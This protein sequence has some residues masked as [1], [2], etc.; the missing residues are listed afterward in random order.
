MDSIWE[1]FTK[2]YREKSQIALLTWAY[3][4]IAAAVVIISG[5]IALINQSVGVSV[6]IVPLVSIVAMCANIVV[7]SLIRFILDMREQKEKAKT[8]AAKR[9][10]EKTKK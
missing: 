2:M 10:S 9:S 8:R 4:I 3:A 5:L 6:L 7:W 1:K